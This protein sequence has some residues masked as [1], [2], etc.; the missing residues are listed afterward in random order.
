MWSKPEAGVGQK[1]HRIAG[2]DVAGVIA[3]LDK[4]FGPAQPAD[5]AGALRGE[6]LG[7]ALSDAGA[8]LLLIEAVP[9]EATR[10]GL[11]ATDVPLIGIGAGPAPRSS[12]R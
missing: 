9:H 5:A 4:P 3:K 6:N 8:V 11:D 7:P 10:A 12:P 1:A 2:P